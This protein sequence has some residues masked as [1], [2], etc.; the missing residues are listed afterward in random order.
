MAKKILERLYV[1]CVLAYLVL[2]PL[3]YWNHLKILFGM[4]IALGV[5]ALVL[6]IEW[7]KVDIRDKELEEKYGQRKRRNNKAI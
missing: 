2:L 1:V 3:S 5:I 6:Y 4:S 7:T